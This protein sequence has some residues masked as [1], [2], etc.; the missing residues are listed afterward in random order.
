MVPLENILK[1]NITLTFYDP[2]SSG[3]ICFF[4][5]V[6]HKKMDLKSINNLMILHIHILI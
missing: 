6:G 1:L 2:S 5:V 3:Y 4:F